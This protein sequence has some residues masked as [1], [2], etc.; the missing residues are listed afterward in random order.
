M[1]ATEMKFEFLGPV[2]IGDTV[3]AVATIIEFDEARGWVVL[4]CHIS[5][6][7]GKDVM[8]AM[9]KGYPGRFED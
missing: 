8:K 3:T 2:Y 1:L 7:D 9:V 4:D 5:D 6:S